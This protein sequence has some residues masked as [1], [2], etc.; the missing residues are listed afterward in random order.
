VAVPDQPSAPR[1][2]AAAKKPSK[3]AAAAQG[4]KPGKAG[5]AGMAGAGKQPFFSL[6]NEEG[7][8]GLALLQAKL[9]QDE[10][11]PRGCSLRELLLSAWQRRWGNAAAGGALVEAASCRQVLQLGP[12]RAR[13]WRH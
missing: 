4:S 9:A 12:P 2:T 13:M 6:S 8:L 7:V 10:G 5:K 11:E 1:Q 3:K